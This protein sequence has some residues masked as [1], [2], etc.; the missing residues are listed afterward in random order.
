MRFPAKNLNKTLF[1]AKK[2]K[3]SKNFLNVNPDNFIEQ[4]DILIDPLNFSLYSHIKKNSF[5][6]FFV[7]QL[8]DVPICFKKSKSLRFKHTELILV[9]LIN[10]LM[11]KG[12]KERTTRTLFRAFHLFAQKLARS[13]VDPAALSSFSA[14]WRSLFCIFENLYVY[15][16]KAPAVLSLGAEEL[17]KTTNLPE[18]SANNAK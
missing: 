15:R 1:S 2:L 16:T 4:E 7:D 18:N 8:I 11:K 13:L 12:D 17:R 14:E 6:S 10:F 5:I 3:L 9:K